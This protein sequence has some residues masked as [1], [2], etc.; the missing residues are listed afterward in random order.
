ML[1]LGLYLWKTYSLYRII[2]LYSSFC[3]ILLWLTNTKRNKTSNNGASVS[4]RGFKY[5][6]FPLIILPIILAI[7][8]SRSVYTRPA[9]A[10]PLM[11]IIL[12]LTIILLIEHSS[13]KVTDRPFFLRQSFLLPV[14]IFIFLFLNFSI[15]LVQPNL[16]VPGYATVDAYRDYTNANRILKMSGF[17]PDKMILEEYYTPFPV[18]P[19]EIACNSLITNLPPNIMHMLIALIYES[20]SIIALF[21]LAKRITKTH[22]TSCYPTV[23]FL[24]ALIIVLQPNLIEPMFIIQ[25]IRFS[26]AFLTLIFYLT[27][28]KTIDCKALPSTFSALIILF[29]LVIIP[30][31]P[32][33]A[34]SLI[35]FLSAVALL[36]RKIQGLQ[37]PA[38]Y[39]AIMSAAYF[40]IYLISPR[41]YPLYAL[42]DYT[43]NIYSTLRD[44][45]IHGPGI[46]GEYASG[47]VGYVEIGEVD[48]FLQSTGSALILSISTIFLI[49][50]L[51]K[52]ESFLKNRNLRRLHFIY[53][54][55]FASAYAGGYIFHLWNLDTRYFIYPIIP[56]TLVAATITLVWVLARASPTKRLLLFGLL[57]LFSVSIITSPLFLHETKP[58][59]A[60]LIPIRS[61]MS[62]AEFVSENLDI[63]GLG[64]IQIVTDWPFYNH[65]RAIIFSK[66]FD[67]NQKVRIADLLYSPIVNEET[68]MLSRR[69]YTESEYLRNTSP[70]VKPLNEVERWEKF[71]K[72]FDDYHTSIYLGRY[73]S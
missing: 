54:L 68:I 53:G 63:R 2:I 69:Y 62:A 47:S 15:Y 23:G 52:R 6:A 71:N 59:Y 36:T 1:A 8:V 72:I 11:G 14:M 13:V 73:S 3:I 22:Q 30:M 19:L 18:V 37:K 10:L 58:S 70:Y 31:H 27:Y 7:I 50:V 5:L 67:A 46:I 45:L 38:T 32:T 20:I 29:T 25:P 4:R 49:R 55:L 39:L 35:I 24:S 42:S 60:R 51:K 12:I 65:V 48:S 57:A 26:I 40:I 64:T 56:V 16:T 61:E 44:V 43:D 9:V 33:S 28:S 66:Y 17:E 34:I 21:L 41:A